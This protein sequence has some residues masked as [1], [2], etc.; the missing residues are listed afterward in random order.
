MRLVLAIISIG[1]SLF[2]TPSLSS[3][4][5]ESN[6]LVL[7]TIRGEKKGVALLKDMK[8]KR[9]WAARE[10]DKVGASVTLLTV[11]RRK[12]VFLVKG[13][14]IHVRVGNTASAYAGGARRSAVVTELGGLQR[15]GDNVVVSERYK[16]HLVQNELNKILMQAAAVPNIKDGRLQG[17]TL[18]EIAPDSI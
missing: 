17:F 2:A 1:C 6:Y 9:V 3:T 14:L 10:G 5:S 13:K 12:A 8:S 4:A 18:W 15:K 16:D 11:K 7:G